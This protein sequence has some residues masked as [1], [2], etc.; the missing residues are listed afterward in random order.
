MEGFSY[1]DR[2][3]GVT[4]EERL[5]EARV[6]RPE[7]ASGDAADQ[8]APCSVGGALCHANA[9]PYAFDEFVTVRVHFVG[10]NNDG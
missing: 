10:E 1:D 9:F 3:A 6:F 4:K 5:W 8:S 2:S 7:R